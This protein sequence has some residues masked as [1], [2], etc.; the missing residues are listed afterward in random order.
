MLVLT[1]KPQEEIRIG[2]DIIVKVISIGDNSVKIGIEAPKDIEI[3]R[4]ELYEKI[5]ENNLEATRKASLLLPEEINAL[6]VNKNSLKK[7]E[8]KKKD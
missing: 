3:M 5:K 7:D 6:K 8:G 4:A 1:R 2:K